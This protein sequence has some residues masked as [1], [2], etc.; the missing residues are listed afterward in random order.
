MLTTIRGTVSTLTKFPGVLESSPRVMKPWIVLN[1]IIPSHRTSSS[2]RVGY[3]REKSVRTFSDSLANG[4]AGKKTK[5]RISC[6]QYSS[7]INCAQ[8]ASTL[9]SFFEKQDQPI[10]RSNYCF[11]V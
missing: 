2:G 4:V 3:R 6:W 10:H 9:F 7:A 11:V 5:C 1:S 8:K